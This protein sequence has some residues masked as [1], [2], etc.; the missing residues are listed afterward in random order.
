MLATVGFFKVFELPPRIPIVVIL[1]VMMQSFRIIV[2]LWL[3]YVFTKGLRQV[4][5]TKK[6][7][8]GLV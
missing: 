4:A 6:N 7:K 8:K 2:E 1:P 5:I 3:W